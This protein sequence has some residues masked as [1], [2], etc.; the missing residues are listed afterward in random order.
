MNNSHPPVSIFWQMSTARIA[1]QIE[2]AITVWVNG[3]ANPGELIRLYKL[4]KEECVHHVDA[5]SSF[6]LHDAQANRVVG[7]RDL[8]GVYPLY[9]AEADNKLLLGFSVR[10]VVES[11]QIPIIINSRALTDYL[12]WNNV[13]KPIN[14]QTFYKNVYSLLPAHALHYQNSQLT[15][16]PYGR[17][18]LRQHATLSDEEY[19][20]RFKAYFVQ[21]VQTTIDPFKRVATHLSGGLDSSSV[22]SVAQSLASE[23][24]HSFFI[25]TDTQATQEEPYV[26]AVLEKC[27]QT[28]RPLGHQNIQPAKT[29]YADAEK[30]VRLTAQPSLL[31]LPVSTFLPVLE[32]AQ[33]A[34]CEAMLSGHGGDQVVGYGFDY[35]DTLFNENN[36]SALKKAFVQY[37][38]RRTLQALSGDKP[39]KNTDEKRRA[40]TLHF[41]IG[42]FKQQKRLVPRLRLGLTL[43]THFEGIASDVIRLILNKTKQKKV[44]PVPA[45]K[46]LVRDEWMQ[47]RCEEDDVYQL[48]D[49]SQLSVDLLSTVQKEQLD[50]VYGSLGIHY[51]EEI[52]QL[53]AQYSLQTAHPFL[54]KDL[55]ELSLNTPLKLRFGD[56]LGRGVLR[57]ALA[58]YLPEKVANRLDKGEF[59]EYT[60]QAFSALYA[61]FS[62]RIDDTHPVWEIIDKR[63]FEVLIAVVFDERY[64]IRQR[65]THRFVASRVIYIAIWL[66][67]L[68]T[69][70]N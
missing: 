48:L 45:L 64:T 60:H 30:Q 65:N 29:M 9:Y 66:E 8:F 23:P 28:G 67:Y 16:Q 52:A 55:L 61:E 41:F 10:D 63:T 40:Y 49:S 17:F 68:N 27:L 43:L 47:Q 56:G 58:D 32:Q 5:T 37:A 44:T 70:S 36:W 12:N 1:V 25:K 3:Y 26:E 13:G 51:N 21:S 69:L 2:Q 34:G 42:K 24:V 62:Q 19:I 4:Y 35:L 50:F 33:Q 39:F 18:Q 54:N 46:K 15:T 53:Q 59:S 31:L 7:V 14:N 6:V 38:D 20:Q 57:N 11:Q 22:C